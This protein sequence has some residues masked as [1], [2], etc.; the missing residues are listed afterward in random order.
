MHIPIELRNNESSAGNEA[1][2]TYAKIE[3]T[4]IPDL[5][6]NAIQVNGKWFI[7]ADETRA[8]IQASTWESLKS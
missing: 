5:I 8:G 7:P 4:E 1:S 3:L 6:P 2:V